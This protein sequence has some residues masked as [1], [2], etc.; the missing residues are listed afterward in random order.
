M[1]APADKAITDRSAPLPKEPREQPKIHQF[2]R[3]FARLHGITA[4]IVAGYLANRITATRKRQGE[5]YRCTLDELKRPYPYLSRSAI[6]TAL[7]RLVKAEVL[8]CH[9][10]NLRGYDRTC[11]YAFKSEPVQRQVSEDRIYFS[12]A[13]AVEH[14]I[15]AALVLTNLRM[16]I[17]EEVQH[18]P[19]MAVY[20]FSARN[21]EEHL[22]LKRG[23]LS[24]TLQYLEAAGELKTQRCSGFDRALAVVVASFDRHGPT[25]DSCGAN[26][27][28]HDP[29]QDA[30]APAP[31]AHAPLRH[32]DILLKEDIE[33][34]RCK[35][36]IES[37]NSYEG[38][39][40]APTAT[41]T[42]FDSHAWTGPSFPSNPYAAEVLRLNSEPMD[43]SKN[44]PKRENEDSVRE[45]TW[46]PS[47]CAGLASFD[48]SQPFTP[49]PRQPVPTS[50][51]EL[52]R[53]NADF[54]RRDRSDLIAILDSTII[55]VEAVIN[56]QGVERVFRWL[57]LKDDDKLFD[58]VREAVER[59]H[60]RKV[61]LMMFQD[62]LGVDWFCAEWLVVA[63]RRYLEARIPTY[64]NH[65]RDAVLEVLKPHLGR[66]YHENQA[67]LELEGLAYLRCGQD[68]WT[69]RCQSPDVA[70]ESAVHLSAAEKTRVFHNALLSINRGGYL[71]AS[72]YRLYGAATIT[73][74]GL[75]LVRRFLEINPN[76]TAD[77][78]LRLFRECLERACSSTRIAGWIEDYATT[79]GSHLTYFM[80]QLEPIIHQLQSVEYVPTVFFPE[81]WSKLEAA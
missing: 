64:D 75:R 52:R 73:K 13:E 39:P 15:P 27:N 46:S 26:Q 30:H 61:D 72:G 25:R 74:K 69:E 44:S 4:A 17:A 32:N 2:S 49:P 38:R 23:V 55:K 8:S 66:Y 60:C 77:D 28:Q 42:C 7:R 54:W 80:N 16:R 51:A 50:L 57:A 63:C 76:W 18:K 37:F 24:R 35:S 34:G 56:Q 68:V 65:G 59:C 62:R 78:L 48:A 20:R 79:R 81:E 41:R 21:M 71:K 36:S 10:N 14:T 11:H 53:A 22:P 31:H 47:R 43:R 58:V 12:V 40:A 6:A 33:S 70:L 67:A 1:E 9:Q 5:G 3:S 45:F 29:I 19:E